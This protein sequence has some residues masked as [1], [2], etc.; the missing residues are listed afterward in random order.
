MTAN[1]ELIILGTSAQVPTRERN[2]NAYFLHW[3]TQGI[4]FDPGEGTQR[5]MT[6][7][8][9]AASR[10][11]HIAISHFHGDHCLG[12]P[13]VIQRLSLDKTQRPVNAY[14]PASGE[15][16]Y[17][18]LTHASAF[19]NHGV[20]VPHPIREHGILCQNEELILSTLPIEHR[21]ECCGYRVEDPVSRT[22][23]MEALK[24]Y[25][26]SGPQIGELKR[27]GELRLDDGTVIHLDDVSI[28]RKGQSFAYLLD[29]RPCENALKLAQNV[30]MVLV[31]A[32]Y[33]DEDAALA[34]EYTHMT[35]RQAGELA[36]DAGAKQLILT[37]FSQ[38]YTNLVEHLNQAREV[39]PNT[40]L[41]RDLAHFELPNCP[42]FQ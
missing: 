32:T 38:R 14:F 18:A 13:G 35:A 31:E 20:I 41:A 42:R 24:S 4:L 33:L 16:F 30:D 2:H 29:T 39:F 23:C 12:L 36:R 22:I 27:N 6:F 17:N 7:A 11:S 10:I 3:N 8:D 9:I 37:H 40:H 34:H 21:I 15:C 28:E 5:Q 26:I 19:Q 25:P 1:R